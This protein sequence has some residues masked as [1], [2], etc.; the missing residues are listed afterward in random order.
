MGIRHDKVR[1][2]IRGIDDPVYPFG[3]KVSELSIREL[4]RVAAVLLKGAKSA[5][6][7]LL[8]RDATRPR[9]PMY[10]SRSSAFPGCRAVASSAVRRDPQQESLAVA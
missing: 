9:L 8:P 4:E 7:R 5:R 6:L 3:T 10:A 2:L 1:A